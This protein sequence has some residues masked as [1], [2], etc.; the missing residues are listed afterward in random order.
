MTGPEAVGRLFGVGLLWMGVHCA[1]MCG[2]LLLGL[3]VAGTRAGSSVAGGALRTLLYQAG[4]GCSYAVLGALAGLIGAGLEEVS[5]RAGALLAVGFGVLAL[6]HSG[7]LLAR[8]RD[9]TV[10]IGATKT[11]TTTTTTLLSWVRPLL[12]SRHPLRPF[13]L[14]LAL[15]FLPC[16]ISLWALGLAALTSSPAWG[17]LVMLA[18]AAAT[19]P[20]LILTSVLSRGARWL[21][22]RARS[23]VQQ[24]SAVVAGLWLVLIGLAGLDLIDHA[25][26][27]LSIA[28]RSFLV[29]LF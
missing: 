15:A 16:M 4:K 5:T 21:S 3:D 24:A 20:L 9:D 7:G 14:G 22:A 23:R 13:F 2:P 1:G 27:P 8:A 25:H 19:T 26:V 11:T 17:A 29:M 18:L 6:L 28:G 12:V 10:Q